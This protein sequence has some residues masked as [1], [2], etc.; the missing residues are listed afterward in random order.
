MRKLFWLCNIL[1]FFGIGCLDD[2]TNLNTS[3]I[4]LP[5]SVI[6]TNENAGTKIVVLEEKSDFSFTV[7][8]GTELKMNARAYYR[9]T[10]KL[11]YEWR[12]DGKVVAEKEVYEDTFMNETSG[13]LYIWREGGESAFVYTF[14]IRMAA[15]FERGVMIMGNHGGKGAF[16]FVELSYVEEDIDFFGESLKGFSVTKYIGHENIYPLC[17]D[18]EEFPC[19]HVVKVERMTGLTWNFDEVYFQLLDKDYTKAVTVK[20]KTIRKITMLR[21]EFVEIP[22]NLKPVD[23]VNTGAISL[24]LD[25]SGKIYSRINYD[26]G[27]PCTGSFIS[28]PLTFDDP[29]DI[30][31]KGSE[32]IKATRIFPVGMVYERE[33]KRFLIVASVV[34]KTVVSAFPEY[35]A[36]PDNYMSLSNFDAE[37]IE[38]LNSGTITPGSTWYLVYKKNGD[39]YMQQF[40]YWVYETQITY[41]PTSAFKVS[42][43]IASLWRSGTPVFQAWEI[44]VFGPEY[45]YFAVGNALYRM[46]TSGTGLEKVFECTGVTGNITHL[47]LTASSGRSFSSA[48]DGYVNGAVY[49]VGFDTGDMKLVQVYTD[50]RKPG[51]TLHRIIWEKHYDGGVTF[52]RYYPQ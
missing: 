20:Q 15:P 29:Y 26:D 13:A 49:T 37:L 27:I 48:A 46:T 12:V 33:K 40:T 36:L 23:F 5:D 11:T 52:M 41:S 45:I 6:I 3:A 16:D 44:D 2:K 7:S 47:A 21:D 42:E 10:E 18:G 4:L 32:E 50:P 19:E 28:E 1:W 38:V 22:A 35:P 51:E 39:Y 31:D 30:P 24:L 14:V 8:P 25:E 43:D 34:D 17:N 9:G